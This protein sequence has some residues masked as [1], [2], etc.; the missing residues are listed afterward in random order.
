MGYSKSRSAKVSECLNWALM[1]DSNPIVRIEA[2]QAVHQLGVL[3]EDMALRNSALTLLTADPSKK[4]QQEAEKILI[5]AGILY[6]NIDSGDTGKRD[7]R[8][9]VDG[10]IVSPYPHLLQNHAQEEIDIYL[11]ESLVGADEVN[12]VIDK[13]GKLSNKAAVMAEVNESGFHSM[14]MRLDIDMITSTKTFRKGKGIK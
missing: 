1:Y 8:V 14:G 3:Q 10:Q 2:L 5:L 4:V 6:P 7:Q 12:S 13:V 11:R 9:T